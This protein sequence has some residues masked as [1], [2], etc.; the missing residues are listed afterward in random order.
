MYLY[1]QF[2]VMVF[3]FVV[4][5]I[6]KSWI[7][8]PRNTIEN[9]NGLN[10]F[11]E[12]AFGHAIGVVI[13]CSCSKCG[14]KKW[15]TRDVVQEHLTCSTFPQ[16]YQTWYMHG[17]GLSGN[18]LMAVTS[19]YVIE[20]FVE[21]RNPM[22]D[23]LNDAFGFVGHDDDHIDEG[24]Q[25][26]G[27][28]DDML[29]GEGNTNFDEL[30]K[31][32]NEPLYEG[33]TKYSKLSFILKLYDIKCMCRMSDKAM[34]MILDLLKDAFEHAKFP[35]SFYMAKNVINKL[36]LNYVKIP[37]CPKDCMLYWGE[38]NESLEECKRCKTS[39]WKGKDKKQYAKSLCYFPLKS[40][41]QRLFMSS[42]TIESMT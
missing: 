19:A 28:Q 37:A 16:N 12:F 17:E 4:M 1:K 27:A 3:C 35:N 24:T 26:D 30:L 34:T 29:H 18:E 32:N 25:E 10:E 36:G 9:A 14:F 15:Q 21:S 23:M 5:P 40:R 42:K 20:D 22:E 41:L 38:E 33:C 6:D 39:K 11:L 7:S 31:D 2:F 13:K 8:K